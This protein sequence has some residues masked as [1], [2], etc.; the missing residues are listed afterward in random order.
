MPTYT[1][2]ITITKQDGTVVA[3]GTLVVDTSA[4]PN[5]GTFTP[6]PSPPG[7][8]VQCSGAPV[9]PTASGGT[10]NFGFQITGTSNNGVYPPGTYHF[11]G[12]QNSNGNPNGSIEWPGA[13]L[14]GESGPEGVETD[15]WQA[16]G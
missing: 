13:G 12:L 6:T 11:N 5:T 15:N 2:T 1:K 7:V 4:S 14:E 10:V 9:W 3:T 16:S 8:L